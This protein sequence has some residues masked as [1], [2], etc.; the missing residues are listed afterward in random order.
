MGLVELF[1]NEIKIISMA[2]LQL[3][4]TFQEI[5]RL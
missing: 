1:F 4:R 2:G 3:M 5:D